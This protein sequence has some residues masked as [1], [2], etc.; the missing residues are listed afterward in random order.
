HQD[1][2]AGAERGDRDEGRPAGRQSVVE[3]RA[4]AAHGRPP[5]RSWTIRAPPEARAASGP[6]SCHSA[7]M[8]WVTRSP[9]AAA[10]ARRRKRGPRRRSLAREVI[11]APRLMLSLW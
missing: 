7:I 9:T 1:V 3:Q 5:V 8:A 10:A 11:S 2:D 4:R 6:G